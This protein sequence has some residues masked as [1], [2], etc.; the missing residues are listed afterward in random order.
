MERKFFLIHDQSLCTAGRDDH[1][2]GS[3]DY[4][5]RFTARWY[6]ALSPRSQLDVRGNPMRKA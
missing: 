6:D 1:I 4:K 2:H 5:G 3:L